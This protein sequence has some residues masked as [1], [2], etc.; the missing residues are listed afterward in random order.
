MTDEEAG[1]YGGGFNLT[2]ILYEGAITVSTTGTISVAGTNYE[3][4]FAFASQISKGDYVGLFVDT[5][6]TYDATHG[7]PVVC[8]AAVLTPIIG[9]VITEPRWVNAPQ[10]TTASWAADLAR[11]SYRTAV[12]KFMGVKAVHKALTNGDAT[13]IVVGE[14]VKFQVSTD[15]WMCATATYTGAFSFHYTANAAAVHI[16]VG[17][18]MYAAGSGATVAGYDTVA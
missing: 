10:T 17:F 8:A 3:P 16:L 11:H 4:S 2:C 12:V 14:P 18:G 6:N 13:A 1:D 9:R 5:G 7:I 15:G